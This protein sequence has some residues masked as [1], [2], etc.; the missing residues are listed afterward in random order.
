MTIH[1]EITP[2]WVE[3]ICHS[4]A[5]ICFMIFGGMSANSKASDE[6]FPYAI[7]LILGI[8]FTTIGAHQ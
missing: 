4:M 1:F 6:F 5:T 2:A 8:V 7:T 3:L